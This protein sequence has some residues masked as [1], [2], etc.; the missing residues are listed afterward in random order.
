MDERRIKVAVFIHGAGGGSWE[1]GFWLPLF[2]DASWRPITDDLKA[3]QEGAKHTLLADYVNQINDC[4]SGCDAD[5]LVLIGASMGGILALKAAETMKPDAIILINSIAPAGIGEPNRKQFA[6]IVEWLNS[7]L[8]ETRD[9]MPD[10]DEET[11]L[12]AHRLWRDE[13]GAVLNE[14]YSGINVE[15]PKCPLLVIVGAEDTDVPPSVGQEIAAKYGGDLM[16]FAGMSHL[17]P[18]LGTKAADVAQAALDWLE[19][20]IR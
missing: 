13:S 8:Q 12:L 7:P 3:A 4:P 11:I 15:L 10:S 16:V 5:R 1:W 18:L 14:I 17:G 6:P 2:E 9:A 20:K 19:T